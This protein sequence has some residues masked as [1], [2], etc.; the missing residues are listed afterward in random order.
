ML[1]PKGNSNAR[2]LFDVIAHL[3]RSEGLRFEPSLKT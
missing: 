1:G 3:Q 2:E